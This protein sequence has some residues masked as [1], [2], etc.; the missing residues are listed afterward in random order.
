[1]ATSEPFGTG[2]ES[3]AYRMSTAT[4]DMPRTAPS[5]GCRSINSPQSPAT[6]SPS[7]ISNVSEETP[8]HSRANPKYNTVM[9]SPHMDTNPAKIRKM[10]ML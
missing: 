5:F 3:D 7:G 8:T 10:G 9:N 2:S 6:F 4:R 1:M